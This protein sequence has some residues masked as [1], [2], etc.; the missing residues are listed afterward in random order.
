MKAASEEV[1]GALQSAGQEL[2]SGGNAIYLDQEQLNNLPVLGMLALLRL[3]HHVSNNN[4]QHIPCAL[5]QV[6]STCH[7]IG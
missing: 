1:N 4:A 6:C 2:S 3:I 5:S 7:T